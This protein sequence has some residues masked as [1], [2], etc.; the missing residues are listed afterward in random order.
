MTRSRNTIWRIPAILWVAGFF[1]S[2]SNEIEEIE[3]LTE[4]SKLPAQTSMNA[5]FNYTEEGLLKNRL[6]AGQVDRY[7]GEDARIHVSKGFVMYIYDSVQVVEAEIHAEQGVYD[8]DN[9]QMIARHDVV[10][11][12]S[13][14]D[15]LFTEELIWQQDSNKVYT[16]K[17]VTIHSTQGT[18]HGKGLTSNETF[19]SYSIWKPV[20][21]IIVEQPDTN[22]TPNQ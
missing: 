21:D 16:D 20:G 4:E 10:L 9:F 5:V 14:G 12:N 11:N 19:T 3:A 2:C 6:E 8:E 17:F 13:K 22:A 1:F 18:L 7:L 15:T